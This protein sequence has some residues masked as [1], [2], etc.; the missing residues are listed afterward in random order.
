[1]GGGQ[2]TDVM[3]NLEITSATKTDPTTE[4]RQTHLWQQAENFASQNPYSSQYGGMYPG[5]NRMQTVGQQALAN[6]ILGPGAYGAYSE[7]N[8]YGQ[9]LG[10]TDFSRPADAD[11]PINFQY[12][13]SG[14]DPN[15]IDGGQGNNGGDFDPPPPPIP[16]TPG[17]PPPAGPWNPVVP[18]PPVT[19]SPPGSDPSVPPPIGGGP[20]IPPQPGVPTPP[21]GGRK[22]PCDINMALGGMD[23]SLFRSPQASTP[24]AKQAEMARFM[25]NPPPYH[26]PMMGG[27]RI[28]QL[29]YSPMMG[30]KR[31]PPGV[32]PPM[33]PITGPG[34]G[35]KPSPGVIPPMPPITG[36]G[37]GPGPKPPEGPPVPPP[38]PPS[39][40]PPIL[41]DPLPAPTGSLEA[42]VGMSELRDASAATRNLLM[43]GGPGAVQYNQV[44]APG[45]MKANVRDVTNIVPGQ[46]DATA[47]SIADVGLLDPETNTRSLVTG[48]SDF[49]VN[50][51][52]G[53]QTQ[54]V[55]LIDEQKIDAASVL[56]RPEGQGIEQYMNQ[57]GVD[58][59]LASA[60][61]D[62]EQQLNALQAQQAGSGAF[63][64]TSS[65]A[66]LQDLGA[67]DQNL[68]NRAQ[69]R[70]AGYDRAA[71][72]LE[73]QANRDQEAA[74]AQAQLSQ[75]ARLQ[76]QNIEGQRRQSDAEREQQARMQGQQLD[77]E[78]GLQ[79]QRL[80]T[81]ADL[82]SQDL[83]A[84]ASMQNQQLGTDVA[85]QNANNDMRIAEANMQSALQRGDRQAVLDAQRN[86]ARAE[87]SLEASTRNQAAQLQAGGM[88]LDANARF[89]Q[90]QMDAANQLAGVGGMRQGATFAAAD[91]LARAGQDQRDVNLQQQAYDYEQWL[92]GQTGGGEAIDFMGRQLRGGDQFTYGRKPDRLSQLLGLGA[93]GASFFASDAQMKENIK[94]VGTKNGLNIYEFN[95]LGQPT[96]WRGVIAQEVMKTRP[97]AVRERNGVLSV[98]YDALGIAMELV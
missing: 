73:S 90:Q 66:A 88:G 91:Q 20:S 51:L 25:S 42:G 2:S 60:Q 48:P 82:Q 87:M 97:D 47:S 55:D 81:E 95:Y 32:I 5:M 93:T 11:P 64:S 86:M 75:E 22:K 77:T 34:P 65:R 1:M 50:T 74:L 28:P 68:R 92:R 27:E 35:P 76:Q 44:A 80:G 69:I 18:P 85:M 29:D 63:G 38:A 96:R 16:S 62:Y 12:V 84:R 49:D 41:G 33:P 54:G 31:I 13:D 89:R 15:A 40:A 3:D 46:A 8:P 9:N 17:D 78:V 52:T 14:A 58:A 67:L 36:P 57:F 10:F 71:E 45:V 7:T 4:G 53:V 43:Q 37:P 94:S 23:A 6:S 59:Q 30:G 70:A 61:Q 39:G 24:A 19:G 56:G 72:R 21:S 98:N 26:S 79:T 83:S